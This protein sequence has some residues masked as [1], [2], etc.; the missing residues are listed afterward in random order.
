MSK[1]KKEKNQQI[2]YMKD[3]MG[4]T[5]R[6]IAAAQTMSGRPIS[7]TKVSRIYKREKLKKD[8]S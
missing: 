7:E 2:I 5:F 1:E 4:M 8:E 6:A 3:E